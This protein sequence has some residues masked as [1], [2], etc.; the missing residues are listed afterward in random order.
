MQAIS[1]ILVAIVAIL[2]FVSYTLVTAEEKKDFTHPQI[3]GMADMNPM[4]EEFPTDY[5]TLV[6]EGNHNMD[7]GNYAAAVEYYRRALAI[8]D[9]NLD[10]WTDQG[11]CF[12]AIGQHDSALANFNHVLGIDPDHAIAHFNLG[13]VYHTMNQPDKTRLHWNR[14]L[15]L[16][17]ESPIADTLRSI[18]NG[19]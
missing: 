19:I 14:F 1:L 13:V 17:P 16:N 9:S 2:G 8:D 10:V 7:H 15:E 6:S 11:A 3:E 5:A 4:P 18:L 12:H